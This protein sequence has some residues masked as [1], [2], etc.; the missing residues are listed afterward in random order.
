MDVPTTAVSEEIIEGQTEARETVGALG[1]RPQRRPNEHQRRV[2]AAALAMQ[3]AETVKR[4]EVFR[5]VLQHRG[6]KPVGSGKIAGLVSVERT[7]Q[8]TRRI[9]R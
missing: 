3:L 6:I 5:L 9:A 2:E 4:V 8:Q 7:P 1:I